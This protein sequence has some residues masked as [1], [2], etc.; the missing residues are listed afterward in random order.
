GE[1]R[2]ITVKQPVSPWQIIYGS[3]RVGGTVFFLER[4]SADVWLGVVWAAHECKAID[5]VY[6]DDTQNFVT[7]AGAVV[8][9]DNAGKLFVYNHLGDPDQTY[10]TN[11]AAVFPLKWTSDHRLRGRAY[12]FFDF[13][14]LPT[15][16]SDTVPNTSADIRGRLITDTRTGA[17]VFTDNAAQCIQDFLQNGDFGLSAGRLEI[18]R[19]N[20]NAESNICDQE[21]DIPQWSEHFVLDQSDTFTINTATDRIN[22]VTG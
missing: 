11:V 4:D 9:G 6:T 13:V 18:D 10:D 3:A 20:F 8:T 7:S 5:S 16:W 21:V 22:F 12:S 15:N 14:D 19:A 17:E 2:T 1:G